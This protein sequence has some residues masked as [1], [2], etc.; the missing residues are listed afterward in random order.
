MQRFAAASAALAVVA[1]SARAQMPDYMAPPY[2]PPAATVI[3]VIKAGRLVDVEKGTVLR[4]QVIVVEYDQSD[5]VGYVFTQNGDRTFAVDF[6][7]RRTF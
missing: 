3:T 2:L 7:V 4:D 6:R 5:R 1:L